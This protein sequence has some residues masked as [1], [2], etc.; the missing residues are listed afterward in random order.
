[1]LYLVTGGAG[2]IGSHLVDALLGRGHRVRVFDNFST[3]RM[4]NLQ[5]ARASGD[6]L[7]VVEGDLRDFSALRE[8]VEGAYGVFHV[9]A[10]PSVTRSVEDPSTTVEVNI[11]GTLNCLLAARDAGARRFIFS[12]SSSVYGDID[13][14]SKSEEDACEPLS[15]YGASKFSGEIYCRIFT[16]LYGLETVGLRYFNVFGPRQDPESEYAAVIPK[17]I[18]RTLKGMPLQIY[19]DGLQTRDFTFVKDVVAANLLALEAPEE[20]SGRIFNIACGKR[21]SV[22]ELVEILGELRGQR[23]DLIMEGPRPGDIRHSQADISKARKFLNYRPAVPF[24]EGLKE[25]LEL[26]AQG[27]S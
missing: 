27:L 25:T 1:M 26:F 21:V 14:N 2:F 24:R 12:S 13:S 9:A 15:P 8:A 11:A 20:A 5:E 4:E 19:G 22:M 10:L 3:G 6:R 18:I 23:P 17:F 7:E 16:K